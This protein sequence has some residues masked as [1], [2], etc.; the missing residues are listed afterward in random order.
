MRFATFNDTAD[1]N[2]VPAPGNLRADDVL[3]SQNLRIMDAAV[4]W[5]KRA[6]DGFG[7]TGVFPFPSSDHRL[8]WID[9]RVPGR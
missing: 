1:F 7:L 2:D 6:E 5:P 4:Y 9:V 3:P 8:V